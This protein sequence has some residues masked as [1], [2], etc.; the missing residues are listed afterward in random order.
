MDPLYIAGTG[1]S[2]SYWEEVGVGIVQVPFE[3][4]STPG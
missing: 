3:A 4:R 1:C 2:D